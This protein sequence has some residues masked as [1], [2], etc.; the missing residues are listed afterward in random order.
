M[1]RL[2]RR[3]RLPKIAQDGQAAPRRQVVEGLRDQVLNP[4]LP[5]HVRTRIHEQALEILRAQEALKA[6]R[7]ELAGLRQENARLEVR[8]QALGLQVNALSEELN[9][10]RIDR[11]TLLAATV[12]A[13]A[14]AAASSAEVGRL[15]RLIREQAV[16][17]RVKKMNDPTLERLR[18]LCVQA[19]EGGSIIELLDVAEQIVAERTPH[20]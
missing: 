17:G 5:E 15:T 20:A 7:V 12:K 13:G 11:D 14:Q 16:G 9:D 10:T 19:R 4:D 8:V 6:A 3:R 18:E 2:W 1:R